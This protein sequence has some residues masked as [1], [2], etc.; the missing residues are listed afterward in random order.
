MEITEKVRELVKPQYDTL[1]CWVHRWQHIEDVAKNAK[2]LA[3]LENANIISC[4]IA[5]Y[6]HDL[7]R[8][9][10][11]TRK[12]RGEIPLPHALLSIEPT[13]KI[14]QKVG[15]SGVDFDEIVEAVA[16]H[17]YRVYE[18]NNMIAK[19]LQ[20]AD[21]ISS[22]FGPYRV[23]SAIKYTGGKDCVNPK[24]IETNKN[25]FDVLKR[26]VDVSLEKLDNSSSKKIKKGMDFVI[27]WFDMFHTKSAEA[28]IKKEEKEYFIGIRNILTGRI[29]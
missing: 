28:M 1:E 26:L 3:E 4:I 7:G 16:V 9:E 24:E 29:N 20:D 5:A 11:E 21:K 25:N 14:L 18:G 2:R 27:E 6:C 8:I 17:S 10:E 15:I 13:M 22:G 23:L 19:I 12:K